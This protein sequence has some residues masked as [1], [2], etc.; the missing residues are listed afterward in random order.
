MTDQLIAQ[1][2]GGID[3]DET[4]IFLIRFVLNMI[5]LT[6]LIRF[7]YFEYRKEGMPEYLFSF[8]LL[9]VIV[10][11]ICTALDMVDIQLGFALGLFALFGILR[12]RTQSIPVRE[13]TYLFL[14]IGVSMINSLV[15]FSDPVNGIILYNTL[16]II[17]VWILEIFLCNNKHK[18][19]EVIYDKLEDVYQGEKH[20]RTILKEITGLNIKKVKIGKID[21]VKQQANLTVYYRV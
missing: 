8:F 15:N 1:F 21:F 18:Q 14:V 4:K 19:K 17:P 11:M 20:L 12:F 16:I 7:L 13:M 6:I 9:G 3:L 10:F 2:S 5:T